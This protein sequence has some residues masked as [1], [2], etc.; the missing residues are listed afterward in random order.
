MELDWLKEV[1]VE[2]SVQNLTKKLQLY[3]LAILKV[4][5]NRNSSPGGIS[6][7]SVSTF[8]GST[9]IKRW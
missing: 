5:I 8:P 1:D 6:T 9:Q 3:F 4:V 2:K 7:I